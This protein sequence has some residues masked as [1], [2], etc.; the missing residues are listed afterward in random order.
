MYEDHILSILGDAQRPLSIAEVREA[1]MRELGTNVSYETTKRDLLTLYARGLI[2]SKSVGRGKRVTW[3]FWSLE[4]G[5]AQSLG[6][7]Q[8]S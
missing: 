2:R 6:S 3:V 1:L 5:A 8:A 4:R 7:R